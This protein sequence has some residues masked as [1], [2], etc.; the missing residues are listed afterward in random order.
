[1]RKRTHAKIESANDRRHCPWRRSPVLQNIVAADKEGR[2]PSGRQHRATPPEHF[3]AV[4]RQQP[5]QGLPEIFRLRFRPASDSS[6]PSRS[7]WL[8]LPPLPYPLRTGFPLA[9]RRATS[10]CSVPKDFANLLSRGSFCAGF[11]CK[12]LPAGP[13]PDMRE[14]PLAI[15]PLPRGAAEG[16]A[17][18]VGSETARFRTSA[19]LSNP[20]AKPPDKRDA[21]T[22][23]H[24][25]CNVGTP[26][27]T[28]AFRN[29]VFGRPVQ[30][31]LPSVALP[32]SRPTSR[33]AATAVGPSSSIASEGPRR[34][35][36]D[37]GLLVSAVALPP[38][39]RGSDGEKS[40]LSCVL[41]LRRPRRDGRR[42]LAP[43]RTSCLRAAQSPGAV[44]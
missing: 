29:T 39:A 10:L 44:R 24:L 7:G 3:P 30:Q 22:P 43:K 20:A 17:A 6:A 32:L 19:L 15:L 40:G 1:M 34:P 42:K 2:K 41:S 26:A 8:R 28:L 35:C 12:P 21:E 4:L 13:C 27:G 31:A 23:P 9:V 36:V 38:R 5:D 37:A 25:A 16:T 11:P 14:R 18:P 33:M